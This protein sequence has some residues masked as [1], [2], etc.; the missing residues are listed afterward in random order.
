MPT[1]SVRVFAVCDRP[2]PATSNPWREPT[3]WRAVC[4]RTARTVRREGSPAQ[5]DFPTPIFA[6]VDE[7]GVSNGVTDAFLTRRKN[8][9][10]ARRVD[11][12]WK[13]SVAAD[14]VAIQPLPGDDGGESHCRRGVKFHTRTTPSELAAASRLPSANSNEWLGSKLE[15]HELVRGK[16]AGACQM[17]GDGRSDPVLASF[18]FRSLRERAIS[19]GMRPVKVVERTD[20]P[21]PASGA[22]KAC[23]SFPD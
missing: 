22:A 4:G 2:I 15:A 13:I 19:I 12:T 10:P 17:L 7:T 23:L 20:I 3:D 6:P 8:Q 5:P 9:K 21:P 14:S 11:G 1:S 16:Y 18:P